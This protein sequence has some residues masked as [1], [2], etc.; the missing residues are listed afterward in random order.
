MKIIVYI[1]EEPTISIPE[2]VGPLFTFFKNKD[3]IKYEI[4]PHELYSHKHILKFTFEG[5]DFNVGIEDPL[6]ECILN[7]YRTELVDE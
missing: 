3:V 2:G 1:N 5:E 7:E 4:I 6:A